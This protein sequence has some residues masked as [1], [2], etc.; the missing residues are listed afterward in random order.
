M[1]AQRYKYKLCPFTVR[2]A[3]FPNC[4]FFSLRTELIL[5]VMHSQL[6]LLAIASA[7]FAIP[8]FDDPTVGTE[9]EVV[10]GFDN[11][12]PGSSEINDNDGT[13]IGSDELGFVADKISH[14][15]S[16]SSFEPFGSEPLGSQPWGSKER[17]GTQSQGSEPSSR[18]QSPDNA[19]MSIV[20]TFPKEQGRWECPNKN[21]KPFCCSGRSLGAGVR[22]GC[23][24]CT[25]PFPTTH[26]EK[27]PT[28]PPP[29]INQSVRPRPSNR[30]RTDVC[31]FPG[32]NDLLKCYMQLASFCCDFIFVSLVTF[33]I[34]RNRSGVRFRESTAD[35]L[36]KY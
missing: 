10:N 19:H 32:S 23:D 14:P 15:N 26:N 13:S 6:F 7:A 21:Q 22:A 35:M 16:P 29:P 30:F 8:L 34:V 3:Q 20:P 28:Q 9:N 11:D 24:E 2:A 12:V 31:I 33:L 4:H 36:C 1:I 5:N 27:C 17:F 18:P 25:Q